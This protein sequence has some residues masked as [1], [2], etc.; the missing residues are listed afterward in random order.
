M[1]SGE[2]HRPAAPLV[3]KGLQIR[4]EVGSSLRLIDDDPAPPLEASGEPAWD[5][6]VRVA[7]RGDV[8]I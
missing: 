6:T 1:R 3:E 5:H 8:S 7:S 4:E 2:K